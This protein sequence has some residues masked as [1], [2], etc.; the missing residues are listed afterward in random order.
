MPLVWP[1]RIYGKVLLAVLSVGKSYTITNAMVKVY[2][3]EY[4]LTTLKNRLTIAAADD[5]PETISAE[6]IKVLTDA[7][8]IAVRNLQSITLCSVQQRKADSIG[9]ISIQYLCGIAFHCVT[10]CL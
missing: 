5:L 10:Y 6:L 7:A 4:M 2:D 1:T 9:G 3:G 8:V